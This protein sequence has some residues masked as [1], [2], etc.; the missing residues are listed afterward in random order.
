MIYTIHHQ[1]IQTFFPGCVLFFNK[2]EKGSIDEY[3]LFLR[4]F[5]DLNRPSTRPI[6][7]YNNFNN[8]VQNLF[9]MKLT[10]EKDDIDEDFGM[11][12]FMV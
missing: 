10:G 7:D 2:T 12:A 6:K 3:A 11:F 8:T 1:E 9:T 5:R 4:Y